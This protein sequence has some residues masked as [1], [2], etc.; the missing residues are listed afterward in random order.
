LGACLRGYVNTRDENNRPIIA[1]EGGK[2][3]ELVKKAFSEFATGLYNIEELRLKL[4]KEGLKCN[5]N[6]F[7]MLLRNKGYI[8][9]VLVPAFKD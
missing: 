4:Y 9:K 3:E 2:Q 5:R 7:W 6:S 8:G 1:P